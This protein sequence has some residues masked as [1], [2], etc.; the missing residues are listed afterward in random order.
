[1]DNR[2]VVKS[3]LRIAVDTPL[4]RT[5]D[6]LPPHEGEVPAPG[7]RLRVPFGN[8]LV[9][10]VVVSIESQSDVPED[11]LK[12]ISEVIDAHPVF[13]DALFKLLCWAGDYYHHPL[14]EVIATALPKLA[15]EGA[16]LAARR[17]VWAATAAGREADRK[18]TRLN[19]SHEWISRMPSS[20]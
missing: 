14:G 6:Y 5:F 4:R 18:S 1:M 3:L 10:G 11:K 2:T 8:R 15:R 20:A 12:R 17:E 16:S 13:D 9:I 19:S 7:S